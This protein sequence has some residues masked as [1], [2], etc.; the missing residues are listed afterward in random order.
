MVADASEDYQGIAD[1]AI[2]LNKNMFS[3]VAGLHTIAFRPNNKLLSSLFAYYTLQTSNFKHYGYRVGTGLKVFGISNEAFFNYSSFYPTFM[4]QQ[5]ISKLL[6]LVERLITLQQRKLK[7]LKQ[8]KKAMLQQLFV[9][10][11]SKLVPN[12]R[13][14]GFV[15]NWKKGKLSENIIEYKK[16]TTLNN[17]FPVLTSS[18][19]GIFLQKEYYDGHQVAS[20]NNIGYN[21]VPFG[22]FTYRHMSDD[23]IFKFNINILVPYGIVST[24]Y[25]VFSVKP[26]T[27]K[28]FVYYY[29]NYCNQMKRFALIQKQG[30]SRNYMYLSK[31]K[32]LQFVA[33][34][35][36]EQTYVSDTLIQ[37][38][39]ILSVYKTML[40]QLNTIKKFL[41]QKLFI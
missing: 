11:D 35:L 40:N 16:K 29:L 7:Q 18:R 6:N 33:P 31:L 23:N 20:K 17:Q 21:I 30:G 8:L 4:E 19:H 27:N 36:P 12:T 1:A 3:I 37:I 14:Q 41:L 15:N 24:L 13:F 28:Y 38:D 32:Q 25:P 34:S 26:N 22:Y 5:I 2:L 10:D 39:K 9:N